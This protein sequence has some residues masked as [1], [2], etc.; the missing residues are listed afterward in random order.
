M[1]VLNAFFRYVCWWWGYGVRLGVGCPC[2]PVHNNIV[3]PRHLFLFFL[4]IAYKQCFRARPL[5]RTLTEIVREEVEK[6][7][8]ALMVVGDKRN[9]LHSIGKIQMVGKGSVLSLIVTN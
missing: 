7:N 1:S 8:A 5:C 3:T 9:P 4:M 6:V 2:P